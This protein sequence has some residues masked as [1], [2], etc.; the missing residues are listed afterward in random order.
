[1][2]A[3]NP[4]RK[5]E[6]PLRSEREIDLQ[7]GKLAR[8]WEKLSATVQEWETVDKDLEHP[9]YLRQRFLNMHGVGQR[10]IIGA[11]ARLRSEY[12]RGWVKHLEGL[13]STDWQIVNPEWQNIAVQGGRVNNTSTSVKL[14]TAAVEKKLGLI[15]DKEL[16]EVLGSED[17]F[18]RPIVPRKRRIS[19]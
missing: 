1:M 17:N 2:L 8:V 4:K 19:K 11:A 5:F 12:G 15:I 14:L 3:P 16:D 9:A 18:R 6:K 7:T 10:A 13:K